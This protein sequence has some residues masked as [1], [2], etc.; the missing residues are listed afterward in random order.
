MSA[1]E[2]A[3][4]GDGVSAGGRR[5]GLHAL[6]RDGEARGRRQRRREE[7]GAASDPPA[8]CARNDGEV[9]LRGWRWGAAAGGASVT[10]TRRGIPVAG[11][12]PT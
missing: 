6:R 8:G 7:A 12:E 10:G 4:R 1:A 11:V 5:R 9:P 3:R 2:T